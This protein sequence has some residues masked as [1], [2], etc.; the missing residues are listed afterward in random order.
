MSEIVLKI[1]KEFEQDFTKDKF[2]ECFL[3][4][5]EDCKMW[6]YKRLSGKYEHET[7]EMF[8]DAFNE[9]VVLPKG[10]GR[11]IDANAMIK[12]IANLPKCPNGYSQVYDEAMIINMIEDETIII[13]A[14]MEGNEE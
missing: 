2:R 7:I 8:I 9:A 5:L 13:E 10:H 6:D 12:D 11:L 1:P 14:D 3:R 4:V